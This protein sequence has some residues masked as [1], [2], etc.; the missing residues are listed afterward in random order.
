MIS[1][2]RVTLLFSVAWAF[3]PTGRHSRSGRDV[4]SLVCR[5]RQVKCAAGIG[6]DGDCRGCVNLT[7]VTMIYPTTRSS[8]QL[9]VARGESFP[10]FIFHGFAMPSAAEKTLPLP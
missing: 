2:R 10:R 9:V 6:G 3:P 7:Y 5:G 4:C 8:F 1:L